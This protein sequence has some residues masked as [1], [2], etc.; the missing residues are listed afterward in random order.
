MSTPTLEQINQIIKKSTGSNDPVDP[1]SQ[2]TP[3]IFLGQGRTTNYI[4]LLCQLGITHVLS[5]GRKPNNPV[6]NST[7]IR[8]EFG[9]VM[10]LSSDNVS[11]YFPTMF[12]FLRLVDQSHGKVYIH[13]EMGCSR[14]AMVV[15]AFLRA[16][17]I[18]A[19]LQDAYQLV[20]NKRTWIRPNDG[21]IQ[22]LRDF[23]CES[24]NI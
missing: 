19:S 22:Q 17:G 1:I 4:S 8:S 24:L 23:F 16:N 11:Q 12:E 5:I 15:I 21:F 10:D 2:I 7:L 20:K 6:L 3:W 13:C 14:S 18:V 9:N